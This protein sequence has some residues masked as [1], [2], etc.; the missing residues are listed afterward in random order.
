MNKPITITIREVREKDILVDVT[1]VDEALDVVEEMY[2]DGNFPLTED[3]IVD[4]DFIN[5]EEDILEE[6]DGGTAQ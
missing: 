4:V 6:D 2:K 5:Y 1:T 3:D